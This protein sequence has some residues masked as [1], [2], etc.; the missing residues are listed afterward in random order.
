MR[1]ELRNA[2]IRDLVAAAPPLTE[3]QRARL[4][5]LLLPPDGGRS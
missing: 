5:V 2:Y 4:A 3:A 1:R